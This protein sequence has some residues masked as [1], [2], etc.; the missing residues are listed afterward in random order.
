MSSSTL[1]PAPAASLVLVDPANAASPS[2]RTP[3]VPGASARLL[4]LPQ[5]VLVFALLLA[6]LYV[7]ADAWRAINH[8]RVSGTPATAVIVDLDGS[9]GGR[10]T[11]LTFI[12]FEYRAP[13]PG[14]ALQTYRA[15]D[16]ALTSRRDRDELYLGRQVAVRYLPSDPA[17]ARLS[18]SEPPTLWLA[19]FFVAASVALCLL[20]YFGRWCW[21]DATLRRR[22]RVL[23]GALVSVTPSLW[24]RTMQVTYRFTGPGGRELTGRADI[25][26]SELARAG[27]PQPG[28]PVAVLYAG[29]GLHT[30]L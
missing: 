30:L 26:A 28:A 13:G 22:G 21:D 29:A 15:T 11:R 7:N 14:G 1:S 8:L 18:A 6:G 17:V 24:P 10:R 25:G 5:L 12:T 16:S 3:V 27:D 19:L 9:G 23:P 20:L 4:Y 2:G